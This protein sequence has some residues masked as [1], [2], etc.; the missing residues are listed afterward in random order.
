DASAL[1]ADIRFDDAPV[2][3]DERVGDHEIERLCIAALTL[4]HAVA[5]HLASAELHLLAV[6]G[7]VALH[8]EEELGIPEPHAISRRRSEHL[9]VGFSCDARHGV[10]NAPWI[11]A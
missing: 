4:S 11:K 7:E 2:V 8:F 1:D 5:D 10:S 6:H 3:Q 9:G